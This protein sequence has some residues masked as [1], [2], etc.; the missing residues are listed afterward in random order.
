M[1]LQGGA[2][3]RC[4]GGVLA[5]LGAVGEHVGGHASEQGQEP[6]RPDAQQLEGGG[7]PQQAQGGV[8]GESTDAVL[9]AAL[10]GLGG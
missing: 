2:R 7:S 3:L 5:V 8:K 1:A 10:E 4:E 6:D 9:A